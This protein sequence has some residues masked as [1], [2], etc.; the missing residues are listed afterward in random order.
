MFLFFFRSEDDPYLLYATLKSGLNTFFSSKDLMRQHKYLFNDSNALKL[1]R[2]WQMT[3]QVMP[4]YVGDRKKNTLVLI[5]PPSYVPI[6]QSSY[7]NWHLPCT[8]DNTYGTPTD[9]DNGPPKLW[10]CF[11][12]NKS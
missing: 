1:F 3:R 12:K 7:N 6:A 10:Y 8:R 9:N 11:Q 2:M 4:R 5:Y